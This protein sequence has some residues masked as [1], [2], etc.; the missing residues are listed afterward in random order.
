[1]GKTLVRNK[2]SN[3][4]KNVYLPTDNTTHAEKFAKDFLDSQ[5]IIYERLH[6]SDDKSDTNDIVNAPLK[7]PVTGKSVYIDFYI[8]QDK[9]DDK[10]IDAALTGLEIEG[11]ERTCSSQIH[12][13]IK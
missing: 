11:A 7:D 3:T 1:M 4:V 8:A 5:S 13:L 2:F 10:D 6:S 9:V 12:E